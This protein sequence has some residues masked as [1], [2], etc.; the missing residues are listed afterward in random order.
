MPRPPCCALSRPSVRASGRVAEPEE[1]RMLSVLSS[2]RT[3]LR[4]YLVRWDIFCVTLNLGV[5]PRLDRPLAARVGGSDDKIARAAPYVFLSLESNFIRY[6]EQ[7]AVRRRT[8]KST[9]HSYAG[10]PSSNCAVMEYSAK[11]WKISNSMDTARKIT[12]GIEIGL[13]TTEK[14]YAP[15]RR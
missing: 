13:S 5:E 1:S 14:V 8:R 11:R 4:T 9:I 7:K 12:H 6:N 3:A 15:P 2:A 10:S